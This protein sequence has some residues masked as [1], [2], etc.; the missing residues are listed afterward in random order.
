M[1][2]LRM[3][4]LPFSELS[5]DD[6]IQ[7]V[8]DARKLRRMRLPEK[9]LK[10]PTKKVTATKV[11]KIKA[12]KTFENLTQAKQIEMLKAKLAERKEEIDG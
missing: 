10:A 2:D 3:F 1:S 8:R 9:A 5:Y 7:R 12:Q 4:G 11:T 6:C